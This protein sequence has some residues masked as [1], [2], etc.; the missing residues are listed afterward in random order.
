MSLGMGV[1]M[2]TVSFLSVIEEALVGGEDSKRLTGNVTDVERLFSPPALE[3]LERMHS[4]YFAFLA[5]HPSV[6]ATVES[7]LQEGSLPADSGSSAM[8][9]FT[10]E[11]T[12]T[13][14]YSFASQE[15]SGITV[16]DHE[17]LPSRVALRYLFDGEP[18]ALPGLAVFASFLAQADVVY[19]SLSGLTTASD[20]RLRLQKVFEAATKA[21]EGCEGDREVFAGDLAVAA[22]RRRLA[23]TRTGR[24]SMRE[25]LVEVFQWLG[26]HRG[27]IFAVVGMIK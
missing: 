10:T 3:A 13:V 2:L 9:L 12:P 11:E 19:F 16:S 14:S 23:F 15:L 1:G 5:F 6:D 27:D 7:Y 17:N 21:W 8:V 24:R 20:V 22:R 18:P 25:W 4:G 26:T